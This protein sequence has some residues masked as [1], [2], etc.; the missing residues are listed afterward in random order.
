MKRPI[1]IV[2]IV[3]AVIIVLGIAL[4]F[5]PRSTLKVT[6]Q[7]GDIALT[8]DGKDYQINTQRDIRL[9][10]GDHSYYTV[11]DGYATQKGFITTR[12]NETTTLTLNPDKAQLLPTVYPSY[13][14]QFPD[15]KISD[16][17]TPEKDWL[18]VRLIKIGDEAYKKVL[19]LHNESGGWKLVATGD[20]YLL[21]TEVNSF[22]SSI[23]DWL[24]QNNFVNTT[25]TDEGIN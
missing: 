12:D 5:I 3:I 24:T 21:P 1:L 22:P 18:V 2:S 9:K 4:N 19:V 25:K 7:V 8:I 13:M 14:S 10:S 17:F 11:K 16:E 15:A 23:Q 6:S 20:A